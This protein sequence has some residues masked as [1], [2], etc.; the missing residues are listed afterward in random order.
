M[1]LKI[2]VIAG[3]TASGKSRLALYLAEKYNGVIINADALQL[4]KYIPILSAQPSK[5]DLLQQEHRL[6]SI[7]EPD[8]LCSVGSFLKLAINEIENVFNKNKLPIIVGG[9]GLYIRSLIYGLSEIPEISETL[10]EEIRNQYDLVGA[11][12]FYQSLIKA[13]PKVEGII[14]NTDSQRMI[15]AFEVIKQ[16]SKSIIEWQKDKIIPYYNQNQF[17]QITLMPDRNYLYN[18]CNVRFKN[19]IE[20]GVIEE[21]K[22]LIKKNIKIDA[23]KKAVGMIEMIQYLEGTIDLSELI[24]LGEQKTRNYAKRQITWFKHQLPEAKRI[25]YADYNE[26]VNTVNYINLL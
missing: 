21:I 19:M 7:L 24:K 3:P 4:Y 9:S 5:D 10:R 17:I 15:R 12:S 26:L 25:L 14:R 20:N 11:E 2:L 6:Y 18:N 16:T 23:V 1:S 13:D 8:K 22:V